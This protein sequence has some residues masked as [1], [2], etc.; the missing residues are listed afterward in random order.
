MS[1]TR[2]TLLLS[3]LTIGFAAGPAHAFGPKAPKPEPTPEEPAP[4]KDDNGGDTLVRLGLTFAIIYAKSDSRYTTILSAL[5]INGPDDLEAFLR[6][7][8]DGTNFRN[9][10][11]RLAFQ[12][13]LGNSDV[14]RVL[15]SLGIENE[16]QLR[17]F[18]KNPRDAFDLNTIL[19]IALTQAVG[20]SK[21]T[22]W[23]RAMGINDIQDMRDLLSGN[24][25]GSNLQS[26]VV[27][28][29]LNIVR[30]DPDLQE[31]V[32]YIEAAMIAL[33]LYQGADGTGESGGSEDDIINLGPYN[34][35]TVGETRAVNQPLN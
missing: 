6:G 21:Y 35:M 9:I 22:V 20:D 29:G 18:I 34:G 8:S 15:S 24:G 3:A 16:A 10:I 17:E 1:L 28:I 5:G 31:Y 4:P 32:V 30:N 19:Q 13:A 33:N 7:N 11:A 25:T 2:K 12:A 27:M 23:L 14:K 26:L